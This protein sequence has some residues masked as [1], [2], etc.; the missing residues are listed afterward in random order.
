LIFGD[1]A[2]EDWPPS[3]SDGASDPW[4][5]FVEARS[6][7]QRGATG[8]A[9][10]RWREIAARGDVESRHVLQAWHFLRSIGVAPTGA[11]AKEVLGA[12]A[13]V[14]VPQGHDLLAA[15]ADGSVR[16]LHFSGAVAVIEERI[17][18]VDGPA[19]EMLAIGR[20]I[21]AAIGPWGGPMPPLPT[22]HSRLTMLTPSGPHFG[23]GP[24]AALRADVPAGA[25]F[26]AATRALV[27]IVELGA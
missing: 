15:Y 9:E 26:D 1:R 17:A 21:V 5:S 18:A 20:S 24:D 4:R 7:L 11:T 23:Q 10:Q 13:E 25:F 8:E 6:A 16:Y 2:I 14:A 19:Q 27:A 22:G 3:T 12:V